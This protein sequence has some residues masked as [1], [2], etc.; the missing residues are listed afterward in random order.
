MTAIIAHKSVISGATITDDNAVSPFV[1]ENIRDGRTS[2]QAAFDSGVTGY[3]DFNTGAVNA[4]NYWAIAG[5]NLQSVG[6]TIELFGSADGLIWT[7]IESKTPTNN[8]VLLWVLGSTEN[9]QYWRIEIT[10]HASTALISDF[11]AGEY[12]QLPN[13][14][15]INYLAP[16]YNDKSQVRISKSRN[17]GFVGL[18][19]IDG[20]KEAD[21][22]LR[23]V[24]NSWFEANWQDLIE[25]I[26]IKPFYFIWDATNYPEDGL[27]CWLKKNIPT[28]PF[29][30]VYQGT[31]IRV[32]GI[33]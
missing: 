28:A 29:R 30:G 4:V 5:H 19:L 33:T 2:T 12:L 17:G 13:K 22:R 32:E 15:P 31:S 25:T 10:G 26:K 16:K 7:S 20:N 6:G 1:A 18:S 11:S 8:N 9:Y 21:I 14:M 27:F 3:V 24:S 23:N